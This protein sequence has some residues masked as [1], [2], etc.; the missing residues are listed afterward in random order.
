MKLILLFNLFKIS[1]LLN[2]FLYSFTAAELDEPKSYTANFKSTMYLDHTSFL[3]F[4]LT[5]VKQPKANP[6]CDCLL[7]KL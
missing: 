2:Y 4:I 1:S 6:R 7:H 5:S 3:Q